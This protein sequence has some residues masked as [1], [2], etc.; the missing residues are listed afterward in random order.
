MAQTTAAVRAEKPKRQKPPK[1][2]GMSR[3]LVRRET[4]WAYLF[5]LP[6][7][8]FFVAFVVLPMFICVFYSFC[9]YGLGGI[10]GFA[11]FDNYIKLF[12]DP[13]FHKGFLN[14]LL[15]VVVAV[16]SVTA[17]SLWVS[18]A[19]YKMHAVPRSFFRCVF[20]LPVVSG[21]VAITVVWKWILNPYYGILN[22]V[23]GN[24]GFD[25][26]GNSKTAIWFIILIL[27]TTSIGQPIVLYVAALGNV[28]QSLVEAAQVDGATKLQVFWK[29]KWPQIMSTTLYILVIT[30][31]NSFQCFAL[32]QLLTRGGPNN[33]TM[34]IMYQVY[35][36]AYRLNDLGYANAIGVVLAIIIAIFSAL[37]FKLAKTD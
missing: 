25:W 5:L 11:G 2:S 14:T 9:E 33:A 21:S 13:T 32:I 28:D 23:T 8:I 27:F 26:L 16:P 7:L 4:M 17:F 37:Q 22:Q 15:I 3:A 18:S 36:T 10:K 12:K 30:T 31:I 20:Y 19:I 29:I 34:T 1:Y 24:V 6:S 35:D